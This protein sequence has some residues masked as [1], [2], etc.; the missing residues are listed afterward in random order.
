MECVLELKAVVMPRALPI[1]SPSSVHLGPELARGLL[2]PQAASGEA[3]LWPPN[4]PLSIPSSEHS[5]HSTH[6]LKGRHPEPSRAGEGHT[7]VPG[8]RL[9]ERHEG[10]GLTCFGTEDTL[11]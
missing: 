7:Y 1:S 5:W 3:C 9:E 8:E 2:H 6:C 10:R 4:S 11:E